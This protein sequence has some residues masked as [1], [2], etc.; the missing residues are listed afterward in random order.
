M[1]IKTIKLRNLQGIAWAQVQQFHSG[2]RVKF[3]FVTVNPAT[4]AP[5][6]RHV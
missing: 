2:P 6:S 4:A 3:N 1:K 5:I